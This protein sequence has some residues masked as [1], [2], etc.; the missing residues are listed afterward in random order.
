MDAR[1]F[2]RP[3]ADYQASIKREPPVPARAPLDVVPRGG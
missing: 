2:N 3:I 1:L